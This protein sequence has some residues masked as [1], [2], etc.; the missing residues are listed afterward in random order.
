VTINTNTPY[1][2]TEGQRSH[3][4]TVVDFDVY[5]SDDGS[6]ASKMADSAAEISRLTQQMEPY[7]IMN[8]QLEE[9]RRCQ[10]VLMQRS[11]QKFEQMRLS[12]ANQRTTGVQ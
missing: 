3:V 7:Q 8:A 9:S 1:T 6:I 10:E 4:D 5:G 11:Q 2:P 12:S